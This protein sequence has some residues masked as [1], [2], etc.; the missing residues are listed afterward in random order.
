VRHED[1]GRAALAN[2]DACHRQLASVGI[3]EINRRRKT[4]TAT[5]RPRL[6]TPAVLSGIKMSPRRGADLMSKGVPLY[7]VRIE[8]EY[9]EKHIKGALR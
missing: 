5:S 6:F 2:P 4:T 1:T 8:Q 3:V 9:K 7:D